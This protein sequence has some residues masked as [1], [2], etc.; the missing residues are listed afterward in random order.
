MSDLRSATRNKANIRSVVPYVPA[1]NIGITQ[2]TAGKS[3]T[4]AVTSGGGL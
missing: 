4:A 1:M 3:D 2:G